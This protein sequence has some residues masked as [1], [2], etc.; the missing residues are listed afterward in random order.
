MKNQFWNVT[1]LFLKFLRLWF[2]SFFFLSFSRIYSELHFITLFLWVPID[3]EHIYTFS[4]IRL[5]SL[6]IFTI[7]KRL[8]M[9]NEIPITPKTNDDIMPNQAIKTNNRWNVYRNGNNEPQKIE[10]SRR[11]FM[12]C[13]A[14]I[15]NDRKWHETKNARTIIN[16]PKAMGK[17]VFFRIQHFT[18]TIW[19]II[20]RRRLCHFYLQTFNLLFTKFEIQMKYPAQLWRFYN[21]F[22]WINNNN[23]L[24]VS[25]KNWNVDTEKH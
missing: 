6:K 19:L 3:N 7:L 2:S 11:W 10:C 4:S 22:S 21:A 24:H 12:N 17:I 16:G 18:N 25:D 13:G 15:I 8:H 14:W 23:Q 1:I 20:V 5:N 9:S